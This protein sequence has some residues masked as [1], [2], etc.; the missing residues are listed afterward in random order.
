MEA[1]VLLKT[2]LQLHPR[3]APVEK[4]SCQCAVSIE[5]SVLADFMK[6]L[7]TGPDMSFDMLCDH[8][9]VDWQENNLI[10]LSYLL[11][12][13]T[14]A[15]YCRVSVKV[16]RDRPVVHTLSGLW[17][18]AEWQ[19]REVYDLFGVLYENHQDLRRLFLE[20]DWQGF[21]LRKDYKD[22]FVLHPDQ[23]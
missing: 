1:E 12:S 8:T 2:I 23:T 19:E 18:I 11:Y 3:T 6:L 15:H 10:E 4:S 20:D 7:K 21:P 17:A 22:D 16:P 5:A 14:H 13:T 9:A